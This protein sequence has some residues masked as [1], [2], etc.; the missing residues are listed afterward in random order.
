MKK[1]IFPKFLIYFILILGAIIT[2]LPF[3]WMIS[4]SLKPFN[5]VFD[6]PPKLI[7]SK[8]MWSNYLEVSDRIP[9]GRYFFNSVLVSVCITI[10]T[11]ITSVLAAFAFSRIKFWGRDVIFSIFLG[12][13]MIPGEVLIIP[14]YI[15]LSKLGWINSYKALIIPWIVSV[16]SIFLLRQFF[17]GIPES[18]YYAAKMD[19][20]SDI[21]FLWNIMIPMSK[22]ALVTVALI[23]VIYSWN[24]FLW[25]LIVTDT[26]FM[27]TLPT[28]LAV[29]TS[30]TGSYYNLL[31]AAATIIILPIII[32]YFLLEKYI[33]SGI[34]KA[35]IK[36]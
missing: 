2:L 10:G 22:P 15:T 14:N 36:G 8:I 31:M 29:F 30:E 20:C 6:M 12:T 19:G 4:T 33:I 7:P 11:L 5:E 32:I 17:L 24:E 27:R 1:K 25:P 26:P 35:G 13:M 34:S 16:F 28:G 9:M 23:K 21:K 3:I 18:L